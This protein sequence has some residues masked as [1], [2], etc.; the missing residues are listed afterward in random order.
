MRQA[1]LGD[2]PYAGVGLMLDYLA[3][4]KSLQEGP[5]TVEK[6]SPDRHKQ[7]TH[8]FRRL[9]HLFVSLDFEYRLSRL[10]ALLEVFKDVLDDRWCHVSAA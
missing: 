10:S 8:S 4:G 5:A 6:R 2:S 3:F 9:V 1:P 7:R